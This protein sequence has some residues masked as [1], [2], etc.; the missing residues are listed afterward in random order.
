MKARAT[1]FAQ[2]IRAWQYVLDIHSL[3]TAEQSHALKANAL[4]L[5]TNRITRSGLLLPRN[6]LERRMQRYASILI[7]LTHVPRMQLPPFQR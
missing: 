4:V 6:V 5:A 3:S 7:L 2:Q 1:G